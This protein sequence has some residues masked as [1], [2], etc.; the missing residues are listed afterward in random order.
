[1]VVLIVFY[2][3]AV[4]GNLVIGFQTCREIFQIFNDPVGFGFVCDGGK[5]GEA[6]GVCF[7]DFERREVRPDGDKKI[8]S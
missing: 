6:D 8:V 7:Q 4:T 3:K 5:G 1:M 2:F